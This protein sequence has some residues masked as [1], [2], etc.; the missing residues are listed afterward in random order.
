MSLDWY[1][2]FLTNVGVDPASTSD[3]TSTQSND[4]IMESVGGSLDV[5]GPPTEAEFMESLSEVAFAGYEVPS[6]AGITAPAAE[7]AKRQGVG[8]VHKEEEKGLIGKI[9]DFANNNKILTEMLLKGVSG[10]VTAKNAQKAATA[11]MREKDN[12]E[13]ERNKQYSDSIANLAKPGLIGRAQQ[14]RRVGG[15]PVFNNGRIA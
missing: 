15:A 8:E 12:I 11:Q 2:E 7:Y 5:Y 14:L 3:F 6:W 10:A 9:T 1:D 13:R 4:D